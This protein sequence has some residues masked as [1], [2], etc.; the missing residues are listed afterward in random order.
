MEF[1]KIT[2]STDYP[3]IASQL[4]EVK[5]KLKKLTLFQ[6]TN[7]V[8]KINPVNDVG[9]SLDTII[10]YSAKNPQKI[11]CRYNSIKK[12]GLNLKCPGRNVSY[13]VFKSGKVSFIGL[14]I[15]DY[16]SNLNELTE[17]KAIEILFEINERIK[18][19]LKNFREVIKECIE[20]KPLAELSYETT[21]LVWDLVNVYQI[22]IKK[23]AAENSSKINFDPEIFIAASYKPFKTELLDGSSIYK[24]SFNIFGSKRAVYTG[25]KSV[26]EFKEASERLLELIIPY[27]RLPEEKNYEQF[28]TH[29]LRIKKENRIK[30]KNK[31]PGKRG[32]RPRVVTP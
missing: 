32:R 21:N 22:D 12:S 26:T 15:R 13:L 3:L 20:I 7:I 29:E 24:G 6:I 31:V 11:S 1:K 28:I 14:K 4:Q 5:S 18:E 16:W 27:A 23:L 17:E 30:R 25:S 10:E 2:G 19:E 9:I 8:A